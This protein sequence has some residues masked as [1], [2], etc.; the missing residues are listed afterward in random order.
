MDANEPATRACLR[1]GWTWLALFLLLGLTLEALHGVKASWYL[2]NHLRRELW[3]LAHA[4]GTLLAL[5]AV[6]YAAGAMPLFADARKRALAGRMLRWGALLVPFGFLLGGVGNSESDPSPFILATP[7][8]A[9]MVLH[10]LA[11]AALQAW[12]GAPAAKP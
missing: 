8:G 9:L 1:F 3:V 12:R 6:A 10:A 5:V 2:D 4:H 11:S 7:V